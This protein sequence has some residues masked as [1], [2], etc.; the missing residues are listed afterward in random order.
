MGATPILT[1]PI[2]RRSRLFWSDIPPPHNR[3]PMTF[4]ALF[5]FSL[6]ACWIL[7]GLA[8]PL[9]QGLTIA[10]LIV[11]RRK[12]ADGVEQSPSRFLTVQM[13]VPVETVNMRGHRTGPQD[14]TGE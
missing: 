3:G 11:K 13:A 14:T 8:L 2:A 12:C 9:V 5:N 1:P 4:S 10:Y 6:C 7:T